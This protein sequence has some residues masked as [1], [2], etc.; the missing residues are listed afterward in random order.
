M[1]TVTFQNATRIYPGATKPSVDKLNLE[2]GDGGDVGESA[3]HR[4]S[5]PPGGHGRALI[6]P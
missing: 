5:L 1:A 4:A 3:G 6:L 2:I